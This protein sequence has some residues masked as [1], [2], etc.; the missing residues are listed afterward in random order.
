MTFFPHK[1]LAGK[2]KKKEK[3]QFYQFIFCDFRKI[4][5]W[6]KS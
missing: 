5:C 3:A 4:L 6:K 1:I 2:K